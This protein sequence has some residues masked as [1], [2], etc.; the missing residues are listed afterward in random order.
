MEEHK[1]NGGQMKT[2]LQRQVYKSNTTL[3]AEST[4]G[5]LWK[6]RETVE[7][8]GFSALVSKRKHKRYTAWLG[9]CLEQSCKAW[10]A[11]KGDYIG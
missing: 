5:R 3:A 4:G 6:H 9:V 11:Y 1:E 2:P 8:R 10:S 7:G